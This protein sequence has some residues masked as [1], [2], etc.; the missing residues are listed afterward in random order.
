MHIITAQGQKNNMIGE[1]ATN[2]QMEKLRARVNAMTN[3]DINNF[4]RRISSNFERKSI[5]T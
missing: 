3:I 2:D 5:E 1:T 4:K